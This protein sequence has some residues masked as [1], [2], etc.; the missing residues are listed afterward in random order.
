MFE[1]VVHLKPREQWRPGMTEEKLL[2]EMDAA[3][4]ATR[5]CRT[6][7][8]CRSR[9]ASTC[10]RP[11][12]AR[13]SASRSSA[14]TSRRSRRSA[15]SSSGAA[16]GAG[17]RSVYAER[18]L[19]G[20]FL[21]FVPDREAIARYGLQR[22]GRARTSSRRAIGGMDVD[23]TFE[24]RER[25]TINVRYPRELRDD[26][27]KLRRV[28]VP[29]PAGGAAAMPSGGTQAAGAMARRT[30]PA[31]GGRGDGRAA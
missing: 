22:H 2:A 9:R 31:G 26:L 21:D 18:E 10:S 27:E 20:F 28:L 4:E 25:Y 30:A 1:T 23:T 15:S 11:A 6:P 17:H 29:I 7:G 12:S 3:V 13:R 8:R 16:H 14:P 19:G 24:G 5:A